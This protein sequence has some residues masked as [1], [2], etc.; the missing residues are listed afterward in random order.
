ME[1]LGG[2]LSL[3]FQKGN[4]YCFVR[5]LSLEEPFA[6]VVLELWGEEYH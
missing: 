3:M 6:V 1:V 4:C 5:L 2:S